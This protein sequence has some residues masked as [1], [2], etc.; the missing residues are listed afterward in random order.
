MICRTPH[1]KPQQIGA[2]DAGVYK[3]GWPGYPYYVQVS[4]YNPIYLSVKGEKGYRGL[5]SGRGGYIATTERPWRFR[6]LLRRYL[7]IAWRLNCNPKFAKRTS[8]IVNDGLEIVTGAG[9]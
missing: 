7:R 6:R 4:A 5:G 1:P 8:T 2:A 9:Q 3:V